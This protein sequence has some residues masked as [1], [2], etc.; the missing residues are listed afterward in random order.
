[1]F[2]K[3]NGI[4]WPLSA[5][6]CL[7]LTKLS[8]L[9]WCSQNFEIIF[10][11][12]T[13][14][15]PLLWWL[16]CHIILDIILDCSV[17][18]GSIVFSTIFFTNN[19]STLFS[20]PCSFM[21]IKN[22]YFFECFLSIFICFLSSILFCCC[23]TKHWS[24]MS[25]LY[26]FHTCHVPHLPFLWSLSWNRWWC[27]WQLQESWSSIHQYIIQFFAMMQKRDQEQET[28]VGE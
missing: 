18:N 16:S 23:C 28:N 3:K 9:K 7:I 5:L 1:M 13:I 8:N 6:H 22:I 25:P 12:T 21:I 11:D 27:C 19:H 10:I 15:S 24:Q 20:Y 14:Q 2:S 4:F 17:S 26:P